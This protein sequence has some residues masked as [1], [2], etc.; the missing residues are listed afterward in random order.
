MRP[1][2]CG[3]ITL[4]GCSIF[5]KAALGL[6]SKLL[7]FLGREIFMAHRDDVVLDVNEKPKTGQ[8]IGLFTPTHV[9]HVWFHCSGA[10]SC[11]VEPGHCTF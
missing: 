3:E 10:N 9:F 7:Y 1:Q 2:R 11:W 5:T 4:H 6:H 8:W